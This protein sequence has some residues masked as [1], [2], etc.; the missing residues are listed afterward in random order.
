MLHCAGQ[1]EQEQGFSGCWAGLS[2]P[3]H[4]ASTPHL[5]HPQ[6]PGLKGPERARCLS[7][8]LA[9]VRSVCHS[10]QGPSS[11][12]LSQVAQ[13]LPGHP[14]LRQGSRC[15]CLA[16]GPPVPTDT[17]WVLKDGALGRGQGSVLHQ[18]G[19]GGSPDPP[20]NPDCARPGPKEASL[21]RCGAE[22][23]AV[24]HPFME[25][26]RASTP[27]PIWSSGTLNVALAL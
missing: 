12:C 18:V 20:R 24:G 21:T 19:N 26:S 1:T 8:P 15:S 25:N 13:C 10:L 6:A 14:D 22:R 2:S 5:P 17:S 3:V 27:T 23:V 7:G 11:F 4:P 9:L 16:V